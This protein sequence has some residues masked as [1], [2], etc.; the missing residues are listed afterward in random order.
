[1]EKLVKYG[2]EF[3]FY[4]SLKTAGSDSYQVNPTLAVG[5]VKVTQD[6]VDF[7]NIDT[8][9]VVAPIGGTQVKVT[10]SIAELTGKQIQIQFIDAAGAEWKAATINI[11]TYAHAD[12]QHPYRGEGLLDRVNTSANHNV[13]KSVAK[14]LRSTEEYQGY[15]GGLIYIDTVNG[16]AG[17]D[18][19]VNGKVDK[20]VNNLADALSLGTALGM[21]DY[22]VSAGSSLQF[23]S[24]QAGRSY[25]GHN[26]SLDLNDQAIDGIYIHGPAV[27]G[28]ATAVSTP[29][30]L[31]DCNLNG[32]TLPPGHYIDCGFSSN[33]LAGAAGDYFFRDCGSDLA[34]DY[35]CFDFNAS[36]GNV[37]AMFREYRGEVEF[38]NMG[39]S[40]TDLASIDGNGRVKMHATSIGGSISVQ[41][42]QELVNRAAFV[43][44]GGIVHDASRFATDQLADLGTILAL[45]EAIDTSSE[46]AARFDEIK[47]AGWTDETLR[48]I[49]TAIGSIGGIQGARTI[50]LQVYETGGTTPIA[51]VDI[52]VDNADQSL[53]LG[54]VQSDS[55]GKWTIGLDDADYKLIPQKAGWVFTEVPKSITVDSNE[56]FI[57]YADAQVI[58]N[59][60]N[61]DSCNVICDLK[62]FGLD[63]KAGVTFTARLTTT[64]QAVNGAILNAEAWSV[65][66]DVNGRAILTLPQGIKFTIFSTALGGDSKTIR[67][68]TAA[69]SSL[70]LA[71]QV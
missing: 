50:V 10:V 3:V 35:P 33:I 31:E 56:T 1:M 66:T 69:L 51:D 44:A 71:D 53:N 2:E 57:L 41:G 29:P 60:E 27:T 20:K 19:Y 37:N 4:V 26:W 46:A 40:G 63:P 39:Q 36:I 9:P 47:G 11:E 22:H 34:G 70:I 43:A 30:K 67:I 38:K 18:P 7:G 54:T 8:I 55:L 6:G 68:D 61:P 5:D 42:H 58:P 59:P 49:R 23:I 45:V 28:A 64:P 15:E 25:V 52:A 17:S 12:A 21:N 13:N 16:T 24:G 14:F 32:V 65:D 62:D 48:S